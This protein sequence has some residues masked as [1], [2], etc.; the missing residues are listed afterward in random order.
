MAYKNKADEKLYKQKYYLKNKNKILEDHRKY[1]DSHKEQYRISRKLYL[2]KN[3]ER[4]RQVNALYRKTH[5]KEIDKY[6]HG[7]YIKNRE[8]IRDKSKK[9]YYE[10]PERAYQKARQWRKKNKEKVELYHKKYRLRKKYN[11]TLDDYDDLMKKQ[12]NRC[13]ICNKFFK[14]IPDLDHNH[15]TGKIRGLLC[16][17]CNLLLGLCSENESILLNAIQWITNNGVKNEIC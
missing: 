10:N 5:G 4:T 1:Y 13:G 15:Q 16:H 7:Y 6:L 9:Y 14:K 12:E 3:K 17:N 11:M 2:S 8:S